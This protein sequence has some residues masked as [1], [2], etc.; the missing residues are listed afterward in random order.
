VLTTVKENNR[1][2]QSKNSVVTPEITDLLATA[3]VTAGT[4]ATEVVTNDLQ[5]AAK[6][7]RKRPLRLKVQGWIRWLHVY[8]SMFSL[9]IVLFFSLTGLTLNHPD[10]AFGNVATHQQATGTLPVGWQVNQ[11]VDWLKVVEYLRS[12]S[13]VRGSVGDMRSSGPESTVTFAA[14]GYSANAVIETA[15]GKY[16]LETT[17]QGLVAVMN[18]FHR[19][20]DA[21]SAW[22]W[23][24]D[25]S[26]G[27]LTL[28]ALTGLGLLLYLK[29][30]RGSALLALLGGGTVIGI[31]M[32][33]AS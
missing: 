31:I 13:K 17:A 11:K 23:V 21:G 15:T 20:R 32:K 2:D 22:S 3:T 30:I 10:W 27:F 12:E 14:P 5:A 25:L 9:L 1:V 33:L 4:V 24:I 29:K 6:I 18:D 28:V 19:G 7:A 8:T 26:A 16:T